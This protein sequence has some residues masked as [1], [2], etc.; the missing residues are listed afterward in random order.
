MNL[1]DLNNNRIELSL[2]TKVPAYLAFLFLVFGIL[3]KSLKLFKKL[4]FHDK[5]TVRIQQTDQGKG[6]FFRT[7]PA[8]TCIYN[9]IVNILECAL[10]KLWK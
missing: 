4:M 7:L 10:L 8:A 2:D 3:Q 9:V 5:S 1:K 6:M